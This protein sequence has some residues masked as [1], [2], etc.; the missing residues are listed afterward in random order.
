MKKTKLKQYECPTCK[1][2]GFTAEH[3]LPSRHGEYG[4]CLTCPI[5]VQCEDCGG[6]GTINK[7]LLN[8]E[9]K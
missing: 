2:D 5:Q 7:P 4:E 8:S 6:T 3:D 9:K 1:G